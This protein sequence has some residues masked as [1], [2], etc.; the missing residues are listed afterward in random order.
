MKFNKSFF[1]KFFLVSGL[2]L[3]GLIVVIA[4]IYTYLNIIWGK[5]LRQ[6]LDKIK[7]SGSPMTVADIPLRDSP[8]KDNACIEYQQIFSIITDGTYT[9]KSGGSDSQEF[10]ELGDLSWNSNM[11]EIEEQ[12][13]KNSDKIKELLAKDSFRQVF[14][15]LRKA[16][17]KPYLNFKLNYDEGPALLLPHLSRMR[18]I[19]RFLRAKAEFELLSGEREKAWDTIL[20]GIK[21]NS[22]MKNEPLIISQLVYFACNFIYFDFM[23]YNLPR[24]GID[25]KQAIKIIDELSPERTEFVKSM[26]QSI[27]M[28]RI[29]LGGWVCDRFISGKMKAE[30]LGGLIDVSGRKSSPLYYFVCFLYKPFAKKDYIE[31]LKIMETYKAGYDIPY[32]KLPPDLPSSE[33]MLKN[34]PRYCILTKMLCPA[35][36]NIRRR[37]AEMET[38]AQEIRL[39]LALEIYKNRNGAYPEKLEA[40]SPQIL[41]EL[42]ISEMT[43]KPFEY[44]KDKDVYRISGGIA[45]KK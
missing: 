37:T 1:K 5:E 26:R 35:L 9:A 34:L 3:L 14:E 8:N 13:R 24:Y 17:E 45:E 39:R 7:A 40:L 22:L 41:K 28:E 10:N 12:F 43:G 31:Y 16:S 6:E 20:I 29:C 30:E 11:S 27:D 15:L 25:S 38:R 36:D 4:I 19:A 18:T 23:A 21:T 44:S 42:P 32:Y 33:T 2:G